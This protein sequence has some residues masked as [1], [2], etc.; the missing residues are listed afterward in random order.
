MVRKVSDT[1]NLYCVPHFGLPSQA[2]KTNRLGPFL[3]N[4]NLP[5]K[6]LE[7]VKLKVKTLAESVADDDHFAHL[8]TLMSHDRDIRD[9]SGVS[10]KDTNPTSKSPGLRIQ[11]GS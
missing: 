10:H 6:V 3:N 8:F 1:N 9:L 5:L 11:V 2:T 7:A 4:R